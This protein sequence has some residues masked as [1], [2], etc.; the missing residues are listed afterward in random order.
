MFIARANIRRR[1]ATSLFRI[2]ILCL[3][4]CIRDTTSFLSR[5]RLAEAPETQYTDRATINSPFTH[6]RVVE[7]AT[8]TYF[9]DFLTWDAGSVVDTENVEVVCIVRKRDNI[10][11]RTNYVF[12]S[13]A[14]TSGA[15]IPLSGLNKIGIHCFLGLNN[16]CAFIC[17]GLSFLD[18]A[19]KL[20][21][22]NECRGDNPAIVFDEN[23]EKTILKKNIMLS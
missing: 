17:V 5:A 14:V 1:M 16:V 8:P 2:V 20:R 4:L 10:S 3:S 12:R 19:R 23:M 21:R 15:D 9:V 18:E 6:D 7:K 11:E 13:R 22:I